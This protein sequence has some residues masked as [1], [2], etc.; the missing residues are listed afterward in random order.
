MIIIKIRGDQTVFQN[1]MSKQILIFIALLTAIGC[2][3]ETIRPIAIKSTPQA[4]EIFGK[5][6]ISTK[7]YE[8][9]LAISPDGKEIIYTLGDYKQQKRCLVH[10]KKSGDKWIGPTILPISGTYQDI[11]PFVTPDGSALYFA[12]NRPIF[13]DES[14]TDYNIWHARKKANDWS[15]PV[16]LDSIIN[17]KGDEFYPSLSSNGNLYFTATKKKGVG[18]EDIFVSRKKQGHYQNPKVLDT[19]INSKQYEFNAYVSPD[20]N[21]LIFS[22]FGRK[23]D[24]GGGDL[25]ISRKDLN[26]NWSPAKNLGEKI[27]SDKLDYCPFID[28]KR[29]NFYFTSERVEFDPKQSIQIEDIKQFADKEQNGFGNI[30]RIGIEKLEQIR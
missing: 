4:L 20:E 18:L 17:T 11:E 16:P 14:R 23:D 26:G 27:N 30:Y 1:K 3:K 8:R 29:G 2:K 6:S 9:D 7:L 15:D 24:L 22:S 10:M 25:Y 5:G 28:F 13:G 21:L 19:A 12:S